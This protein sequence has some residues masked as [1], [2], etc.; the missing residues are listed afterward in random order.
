MAESGSVRRRSW[1]SCGRTRSSGVA[2]AVLLAVICGA[3]GPVGAVQ[4]GVASPESA[5]PQ[6]ISDYEPSTPAY[7]GAPWFE[8]GQ[9]YAGNFPDPQIVRDGSKYWAYATSTGGPT[10]PAMWS[11]DLVTWNARDAYVPNP[12]NADPY[13]NDAFPVPPS[14]SVGGAVVTPGKAQWAPGVANIGGAWVAYT[15]W[16]ITP[17]RRCISAAR[18]SS[19]SG[20]FVDTSSVPLACDPGPA[21]SIDA[22]PFL[23]AAG[24]PW[25]TWKAESGDGLPARIYSRALSADGL[26]FKAGS[27]ASLLLVSVLAWEGMV[28]EN[29]SMLYS[30]GT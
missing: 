26:S 27:S 6:A 23:D 18:S 16:E 25:L 3:A 14:W 19:P 17:G 15:S 28:V 22:S 30:G 24:Q 7:A 12:Y 11:T 9:P 1:R 21:G 10:L 8:P 5:I 2:I 20:P 4:S 29:P 13:F